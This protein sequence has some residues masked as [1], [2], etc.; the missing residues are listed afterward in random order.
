MS[1]GTPQFLAAN[2]V[3]AYSMILLTCEGQYLL[4]ERSATKRFAP[5]K[6]T[7]LGGRIGPD[8]FEDV[9]SAALRELRE[10]AGI[11]PDQLS[12]FSLRRALLHNR[13]SE[14]LTLLLYFTGELGQQVLPDCPEGTLHWVHPNELDQHDLIDNAAVVIRLLIDDIARDPTGTEPVV[15]GAARYAPDGHLVADAIV[16]A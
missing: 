11:V 7:G 16:W 3:A 2:G 10:E 9:H 15:V 4:L 1:L 8:E 14:P 5:G 12:S 6:W 13:P